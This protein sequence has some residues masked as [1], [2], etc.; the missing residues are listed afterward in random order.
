MYLKCKNDRMK[1]RVEKCLRGD[2][3]SDN[4]TKSYRLALT[5]NSRKI[6]DLINSKIKGTDPD[7]IGVVGVSDNDIE[8][9]AQMLESNK[10]LY[11]YIN[12][13]VENPKAVN[14]I[15][16][17]ESNV[18]FLIK[19]GLVEIDNSKQQNQ[20]IDNNEKDNLELEG[21]HEEIENPEESQEEPHDDNK[22]I[23]EKPKQEISEEKKEE[24]KEEEK[25][26]DEKE[27]EPANLEEVMQGDEEKQKSP[28][29][30]AFTK[31]RLIKQVN[32]M[33]M[34]ENLKKPIREAYEKMVY[35]SDLQDPN[36]LRN[37]L[38]NNEEAKKAGIDPASFGNMHKG[39]LMN[40][41]VGYT[42]EE[43]AEV[44]DDGSKVAVVEFPQTIDEMPQWLKNM[45]SDDIVYYLKYEIDRVVNS[46][47]SYDAIML[48]T[49]ID[50]MYDDAIERTEHHYNQDQGG[51]ANIKRAYLKYI[52]TDSKNNLK[53]EFRTGNQNID[54]RL[55]T[56]DIDWSNPR[57]RKEM[58]NLVNR[59]DKE[60]Y[61][62]NIENLVKN[63]SFDV[64]V[65]SL[66][67]A[68]EL[69]DICKDLKDL[70]VNKNIAVVVA[71]DDKEVL[72][73]VQKAKG[74]DK[75]IT[76]KTE[77]EDEAHFAKAVAGA[78]AVSVGVG[79][80]IAANEVKAND[81]AN[82]AH[83]PDFTI[84]QKKAIIMTDA[85]KNEKL[86]E[87]IAMHGDNPIEYMAALTQEMLEAEDLEQDREMRNNDSN[88]N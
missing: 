22:E 75:E 68:N 46:N 70:N 58:I 87:E 74:N 32:D 17:N 36:F 10:K 30:L 38:D 24:E 7:P 53:Q 15:D 56:A 76:I 71:T 69:K 43:N 63:V 81:V 85:M 23:K 62:Q 60:A 2:F 39:I 66:D 47:S 19:I 25:K 50:R 59:A 55:N 64:V 77:K 82:I 57:I 26:K 11:A 65:H 20:D 41:Y 35:V 37:Y 1:D 21:Q 45:V 79:A 49:P 72:N 6:L 12:M 13:L 34:S 84:E 8:V 78:I 44:S 3:M 88:A 48:L 83:N 40:T 18:R 31:E 28:E 27:E 42:M 33:K 5:E 80:V 51:N 86:M 9:A 52:S 54:V 61:N 29:Y 16:A 73:E 4:K 14:Q 67:D